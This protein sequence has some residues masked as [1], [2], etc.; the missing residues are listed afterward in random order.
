MTVTILQGDCIE[1]MRGMD[2]ES[3][4]LVV[5]SPPYWGLRDYGVEGQLGLEPTLGEHLEN[6]VAVF[7]AVKRI[8]K[9]HGSVWLNYGDCYA[10]APNERSAADTKA[11]GSDDRTFRDKPFGTTGPIYNKDHAQ[12]TTHGLHG[13]KRESGGRIEAGG[14]LKPKDLC[15]IPNR[16]AIALQEEGWWIRSEIIWGKPNAMPDSNGCRRPSTAH[17][18]IFLLSKSGKPSCWRAFDTGEWTFKK[19]DLTERLQIPRG[20][21]P[22]RGRWEGYDFYYNAD[23]V[24]TERSSDENANGFRGGSYVNGQPGKRTATGNYK[25]PDGWDTGPGAHGTVHREGRGK[26][27]KQRGHSRR[28]AGFNERWDAMSREEQ[29]ENGRF[30]RNYEPAPIQ[31]WEISTAGFS[32]AHFATFPPE[33]VKRCLDAG[34]PPGGVVFDPFGGAGTTGLVAAECGHDCILAELS[35]DYIN[36]ARDRLRRGL[37]PVTCDVAEAAR[38][39]GPLFAEVTA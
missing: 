18:K 4:D 1:V 35:E 10:T 15:M 27:K 11:A 33:L 29:Q 14:V 20:K 5:T 13:D 30:L 38:D 36:I 39:H 6:M 24:R 22:D 21:S 9:P 2:A 23:E 8:L 28:H 25:M 31:V 19:P 37:L 12:R 3:V 16:L 17:E 26:G 7:R 32:D 34:C